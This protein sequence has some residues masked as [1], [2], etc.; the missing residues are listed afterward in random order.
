MRVLL[1]TASLWLPFVAIAQDAGQ[2]ALNTIDA[3]SKDV[4][5]CLEAPYQVMRESMVEV[6]AAQLDGDLSQIQQVQNKLLNIV[7]SAE[8]CIASLTAKYPTIDKSS[9]LQERV[10]AQVEG[11]C[12]S[13][14]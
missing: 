10:L 12:P 8:S 2:T 7:Q 9:V 13:P 5:S 4:C 1:F 6:R 3:A 14:I 11:Q